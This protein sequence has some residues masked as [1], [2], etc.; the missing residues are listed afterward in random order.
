MQYTIEMFGVI[1]IHV[2]LAVLVIGIILLRRRKK[3]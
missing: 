3:T 1:A 2:V